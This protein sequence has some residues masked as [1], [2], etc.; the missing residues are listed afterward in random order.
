M[1][2]LHYDLDAG[3]DDVVEVTL[4]RR[5]NVQLMDDSNFENYQNGREFHYFGGYAKE[6]PIRLQ[7][8]R[9]GRWHLVI[10][11]GGGAGTVKAAVQT[12]QGVGARG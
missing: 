9:Q 12:L 2:Y 3:P 5:A 8:P 4:D 1:N 10:D 7:P 11:L 6:S